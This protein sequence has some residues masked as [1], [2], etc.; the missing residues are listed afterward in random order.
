MSFIR[1]G[2]FWIQDDIS[3]GLERWT[4]SI[5]QLLWRVTDCI[6]RSHVLTNHRTGRFSP[7]VFSDSQDQSGPKVSPIKRFSI[8]RLELCGT[9]LLARL[10]HYVSEVLEINNVH[11]WT[12]ITIML[13]W[14]QGNA[15][16][17][18]PFVGNQMSKILSIRPMTFDD[19]YQVMII[20]QTTPPKGCFRLNWLIIHGRA[21]LVGFLMMDQNGPRCQTS[22]T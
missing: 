15:L 2:S 12:N 4:Y 11:T 19:T 18:K 17:F 16:Q 7:H 22:T 20:L 13:T 8:P 14:L 9:V 1:Y 21:A 3:L 5:A 10:S 6:H